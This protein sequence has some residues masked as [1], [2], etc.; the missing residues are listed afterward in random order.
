MRARAVPKR[1]ELVLRTNLKIFE[2]VNSVDIFAESKL[3]ICWKAKSKDMLIS[4][5]F[6]FIRYNMPQRS[7][8]PHLN[9]WKGVE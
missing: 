4:R 9:R 2:E 6:I 3:N 5:P 1:T 8:K 7:S